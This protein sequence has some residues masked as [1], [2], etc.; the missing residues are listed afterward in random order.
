METIKKDKLRQT[1]RTNYGKVAQAGN[2]GCCPTSSCCSPRGV[3]SAD[4]ISVQLGYSHEE[5]SAV[6]EGPIWDW[7]AEIRR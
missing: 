2:S 3:S 5:V 6:P 4:P 1:M 7:D